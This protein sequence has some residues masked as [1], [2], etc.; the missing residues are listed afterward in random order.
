M[1]INCS[2]CKEWLSKW[3]SV[4][5]KGNGNIKKSVFPI[6]PFRIWI[7][8]TVQKVFRLGI[9]TLLLLNLAGVWETTLSSAYGRQAMARGINPNKKMVGANNKPDVA[10]KD[11]EGLSPFFTA[12]EQN[13]F[14]T[15]FELFKQH[16]DVNAKNKD[17]MTPLM[18]ATK[19]GSEKMVQILL[20]AKDINLNFETQ[21]GETALSLA[22]KSNFNEI[23]KLLEE[24]AKNGP[25]GRSF[26]PKP[27]PNPQKNDPVKEPNKQQPVNPEK[28]VKEAD[29]QQPDVQGVAAPIDLALLDAV[30]TD[31]LEQAKL[32]I[33]QGA[34]M[35]LKNR[36][37]ETLL[38]IAAKRGNTQMIQIL[39]EKNVHDT[40]VQNQQSSNP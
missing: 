6:H 29:D 3:G 2:R 18:L 17:G 23:A 40:P 38:V 10:N 37:G 13:D 12:I 4:K 30:K 5:D 16:P 24:R 27:I 20:E 19:N 8:Q 33:A 35:N 14:K 1:G 9:L 31:N 34:N 32:M 22:K 25:P 21:N 39:M 36:Q 11:P 7:F 26:N 15:F 28:I